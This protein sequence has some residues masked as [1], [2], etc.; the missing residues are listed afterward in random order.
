MRQFMPL[1]ISLANRRSSETAAIN[2][3]ID[4]GKSGMLRAVRKFR[5]SGHAKFEV[6]ALQYIE[7]AMDRANSS[8]GFWRRLFRL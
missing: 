8:G 6:F 5:P 2:N 3:L 1:L 4:A 7:S